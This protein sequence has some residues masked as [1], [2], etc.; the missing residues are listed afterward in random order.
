[1]ADGRLPDCSDASYFSDTGIW[2]PLVPGHATPPYC[3]D[4]FFGGKRY[5]RVIQLVRDAPRNLAGRPRSRRFRRRPSPLAQAL[6][7]FFRGSA[8]QTREEAA[9]AFVE[10][11]ET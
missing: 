6:V 3:G 8:A 4:H 11:S 5:F 1:M 10:T 9:I 2:T 7:G